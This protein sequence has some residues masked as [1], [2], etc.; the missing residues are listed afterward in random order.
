M[1]ISCS[2]WSFGLSHKLAAK[3][4]GKPWGCGY[5]FAARY[6][7]RFS[8]IARRERHHSKARYSPVCSFFVLNVHPSRLRSNNCF[9][10][11]GGFVFLPAGMR[12]KKSTRPACF[13]RVKITVLFS[14]R[15]PSR[16]PVRCYLI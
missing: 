10:G 12:R 1:V 15:T 9:G 5:L 8:P 4:N 16:S 14:H 6:V 11:T 13:S 2:C 7:M 3:V